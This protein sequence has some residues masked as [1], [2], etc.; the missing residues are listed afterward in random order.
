MLFRSIA[1]KHLAAKFGADLVDHHTYTIVGDG[2]LMEGISHEAISMAG[3]LKLDK[4]IVLF[5]DNHIC[6]DGPTEMTV[7]DDQPA[8]FKASGWDVAEVDGHD[9]AAIEAAIEAAKKSDKPSMIACRTVIGKFAPT[10][11]DSSGCHGAPLGVEEIAGTRKAMGWESAEIGSAS[12]RE[13]V[14]RAV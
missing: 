4:L 7:T 6:I 11:A 1:E 2:C 14:F 8:R 3:H 10:K 9:F 5:D 12:C 13:R